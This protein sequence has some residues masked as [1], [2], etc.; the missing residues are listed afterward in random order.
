M[1][2]SEPLAFAGILS[3]QLLDTG[4]QVFHRQ[5]RSAAPSSEL[6]AWASRTKERYNALAFAVQVGGGELENLLRLS[7]RFVKGVTHYYKGTPPNLVQK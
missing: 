4:F 5:R 3:G 2:G 6:T 7:A 1:L